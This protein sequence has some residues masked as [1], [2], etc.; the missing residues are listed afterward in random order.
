[1]MTDTEKAMKGNM[2]KFSKI[3]VLRVK[4]DSARLD[5]G[6]DRTRLDSTRFSKLQTRL[7][8]T[9]FRSLLF[10]PWV[11]IGML[12]GFKKWILQRI[13]QQ[14]TIDNTAAPTRMRLTV[15]G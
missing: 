15:I 2:K 12:P 8:S 11:S 13:H 14:S 5:G 9:R 3:R 6:S 10:I 4:L 1:M 7:D